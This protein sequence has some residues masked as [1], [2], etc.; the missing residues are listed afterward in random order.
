MEYILYKTY[1]EEN[2]VVNV[3][4]PILTEEERARRME[5]IYKAAQA[6]II[7]AMRNKKQ[8]S[9]IIKSAEK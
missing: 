3:Y 2:R 7:E 4:K 1:R 9:Q 5:E 8:K 6:I